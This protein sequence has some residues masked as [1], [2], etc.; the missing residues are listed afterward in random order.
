M[1]LTNDGFLGIN[2]LN[3][4]APLHTSGDVI[5]NI[6]AGTGSGIVY[7]GVDGK[8]HRYSF[9]GN[10]QQ[11]LLG[12]GTFGYYS[13]ND[14]KI[15]GNNIYN[16][17]T[18]NVGINTTA[19]EYQLDVNGDAKV[20]GEFLVGNSI[21]FNGIIDQI[22][23]TTGN[24]DFG[25]TNLST[26]GTLKTNS[27]TS[28]S[29]TLNLGN[30]NIL[31]MGSISA[32][33]TTFT[34]SST[35]DNLTVNNVATTEKLVTNGIDVKHALRFPNANSAIVSSGDLSIE[36]QGNLKINTTG[37]TIINSRLGVGTDSPIEMLDVA[38]NC[39][40]QGYL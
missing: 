32:A 27:I 37:N 7:T 9:T 23:T 34:G 31:T 35:F 4:L 3:P 5:F 33:G 24:L 12:D 1:I 8:L 16:Q 6:L 21:K 17:N 15:D 26:D 29:G 25:T 28:T 14:W 20:R 36:T 30:T 11:V 22:T 2:V 18:G 19:P 38:G 13:D 39:H 10:N 40:I